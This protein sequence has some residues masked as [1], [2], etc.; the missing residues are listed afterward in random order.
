LKYSPKD[1]AIISPYR[2]QTD[3]IKETVHLAFGIDGI[4]SFQ[5]VDA[6]T[7]HAFQGRQNKI[8]IYNLV[9]DKL[10]FGTRDRFKIFKDNLFNVALSRAESK[11]IM[12]ANSETAD[13][14]ELPRVAHLYDYMKKNG[15]VFDAKRIEDKFQKVDSKIDE[16]SKSLFTRE[17]RVWKSKN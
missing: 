5:F 16:A 13:A 15:V 4:E 8:V 2:L 10:V 12:V 6:N 17:S 1:I 9:L 7:V 11:L 3:L 14:S